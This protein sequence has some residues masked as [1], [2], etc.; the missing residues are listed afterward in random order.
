VRKLLAIMMVLPLFHSAAAELHLFAAASLSDALKEIDAGFEKTSG[1]HVSANF[2]A[3]SLLARQ[4]EE[5]APADVFVSADEA[6][7]DQLQE[8][9]LID[10]SSRRDL[11]GN[12]LVIVIAA[13]SRLTIT[14]PQDLLQPPFRRIALADPQAVPAGIYAR[15]FLQRVQL[16]DQLRARIVPTENVRAALAAV[17]AGNADA[18]FVYK[19]DAAIS[20]RVRVA[21]AV[22]QNETPA[23][24]YVVAIMGEAKEPALAREFVRYLQSP[25]AAAVFERF[26]FVVKR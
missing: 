8:K 2:A 11:L 23:I 25:A 19:T 15:E 17:A 4:I 6:K 1:H 5:G 16:F 9:G 10:P 18:A 22:P 14:A 3:S 20:K 26:G 12:S 13:D 7:M 21:Y 24:R